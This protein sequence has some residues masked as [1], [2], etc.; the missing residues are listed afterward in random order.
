[1]SDTMWTPGLRAMVSPG[2]DVATASESVPTRLPE[3]CKRI[4]IFSAYNYIL[5]IPQI[6][7]QRDFEYPLSLR[8]QGLERDP[9]RSVPLPSGVYFAGKTSGP[10]L[11]ERK[12]RMEPRNSMSVKGD[13]S[14][15]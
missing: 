8:S 7:R 4:V 3:N 1:M 5:S 13:R 15:K 9:G 14:V 11:I 12:K 10:K 2:R 6:H